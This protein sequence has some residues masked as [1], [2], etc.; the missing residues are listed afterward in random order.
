MPGVDEFQIQ[1]YQRK[2]QNVSRRGKLIQIELNGFFLFIHLRM[3]GNILV[4]NEDT[5]RNV[6]HDRLVMS[7]D[8]HT[9]LVFNDPR[10]FGRIWLTQDIE[11]VIGHLGPEPLSAEFTNEEIYAKLQRTH[12]Q[13][14]PLLLDQ[15][16][17]AGLGNI[18]TDE[19][20]FRAGIHPSTPAC[21]LDPIRSG[22]LLA[23]I[24]LVLED[25]IR[26]NGASIDWVYRGGDFQNYFQ[27]YQRQGEPCPKCG[28]PI[29]RMV[30]GSRGTHF[31]PQCQ[32]Q[33]DHNGCHK[34]TKIM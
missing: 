31:C 32:P 8:D 17:I 25:G 9:Q 20:L 33:Q 28:I 4:E 18:Y 34:Y 21:S 1:I 29:K 14:K 11:K 26:R 7:F 15:K 30:I 3:S 19:A 24:K 27:V 16:F 23:S 12:R 13:I 22:A 10:K 2:I 5:K 6:T